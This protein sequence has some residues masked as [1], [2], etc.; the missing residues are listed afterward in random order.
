MKISGSIL[1]VT[2]FILTVFLSCTKDDSLPDLEGNLVGYVFK[3]D[4]FSQLLDNHAGVLIT[5]YG[6]SHKYHTYSDENGR[7]EFKQLPAGTYELHFD[8]EGFGTLKQ[9]GVKHL[10]GEPTILGMPFSASSGGDA[11]FI[12]KF[13]TAKI[14]DLKIEN[15]TIKCNLTFSNTHPESVWIRV[16]LSNIEDFELLKGQVVLDYLAKKSGDVYAFKLNI[17]YPP[18]K[19]G[20][21]VFLRACPCPHYSVYIVTNF[22]RAIHGIDTY[23]DYEKNIVIYPALGSESEQFSFMYP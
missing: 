7:F 10:G 22:N 21:T 19:S 16:Y 1:A 11:F 17:N 18:F 8:K 5:A 20:E 9:F 12:F 4:E 14:L 3:F 13:Q 23:F 2:A 15:N 6:V